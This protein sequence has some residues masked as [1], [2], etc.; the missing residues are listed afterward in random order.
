MTEHA[1]W[2][3]QVWFGWNAMAVSA[4]ILV[5][6]Y[7][8]IISEKINRAVIALVGAGVM[9]VI[10]VLN[11]EAAIRGI[12]FNTIAL[13]TGM[14]ILVSVTR[15]SGLFQYV[16]I[17][18]AKKVQASPRGLLFVLPIVTAVFSALLDNVTTVLLIVP[19]TL[20]IT[21]ELKVKAYPF[22]VAEILASN[23]GGTSTLI[24]DP[25]NIMIGSQTDLTFNDFLFNLAPVVIVIQIATSLVLDFVWGRKMAAAPEARARV[26]AF[27]E[28]EA[29]KDVLLLKQSLSVLGLVIL[30]FVTAR[31]LHLEP[32]TIAMFGAALLMLIHNLGRSP[33]AQSEDVHHTF[34]EVEWITIFF[35]VGLFIVVYG[36]ETSGLLKLLA[37]QLVAAT[38]GDMTRTALAILWASAILSAIV[39]NIPFVA[40][41]IPLI[42]AMAPTFGGPENLEPLWWSLSLGACLGGNGTLIGAS[43][44]LTV[45]GLAERA[46]QPIRFI[47]YMKS[48][49]L[50]MILS[51]AI[52]H[53]YVWWRYL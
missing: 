19:V 48:A 47:P 42:K 53:V 30:A 8:A 24:G 25:P 29:I 39:D 51:V 16:A 13:L 4:T 11:Q 23:I 27:H 46:G 1:A 26:M 44:N 52:S 35:F 3:P 9:I 34:T 18:S 14:M 15:K 20:V 10:G 50:L 12:D 45:A 21:D 2:M 37:E 49:F 36:V 38:G 28:N 31:L 32:G 22:L 41:M 33:E 6:T 5:I 7:A 17:W 43:A 40:T